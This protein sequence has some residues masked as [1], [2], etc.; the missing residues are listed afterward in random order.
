MNT[1]RIDRAR[2]TQGMFSPRK[3]AVG[4]IAQIG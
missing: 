1:L 2:L 4:G 3:N